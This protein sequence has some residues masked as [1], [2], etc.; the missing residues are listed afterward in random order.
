MTVDDITNRLAPLCPSVL[1][2]PLESFIESRSSKAGVACDLVTDI[3][4]VTAREDTP[5]V[6]PGCNERMAMTSLA[7]AHDGATAVRVCP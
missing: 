7:R 5:G 1:K 4:L 3:H 2:Q 6:D